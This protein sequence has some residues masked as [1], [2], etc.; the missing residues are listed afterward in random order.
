MH[1][2]VDPKL[3]QLQLTTTSKYL[4]NHSTII[5]NAHNFRLNSYDE[6]CI[7]TTTRVIGIA[8]TSHVTKSFD[9]GSFDIILVMDLAM[10]GGERLGTPPGSHIKIRKKIDLLQRSSKNR[11]PH[12]V[13]GDLGAFQTHREKQM[14]TY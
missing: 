4:I 6:L 12:S 9:E 8:P 3:T 10:E 1:F 11:T 14:T 5:L 13:I 2:R 7:P